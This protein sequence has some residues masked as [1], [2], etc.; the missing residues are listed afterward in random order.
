METRH[1]CRVHPSAANPPPRPSF[2]GD[3]PPKNHPSAANPP[4]C[5]RGSV[6]PRRT[7][8]LLAR[9]QIIGSMRDRR[10]TGDSPPGKSW[11]QSPR[12]INNSDGWHRG[13]VTTS[14]RA[15]RFPTTILG[16]IRREEN[17]GDGP[18]DFVEGYVINYCTIDRIYIDKRDDRQGFQHEFANF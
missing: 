6:A 4:R 13:S 12:E 8:T 15:A 10:N 1:P 11:G 16:S 2:F 14:P 18:H 7:F 5:P 3:S 9:N 17:T